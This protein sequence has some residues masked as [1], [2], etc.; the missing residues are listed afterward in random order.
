MIAPDE[1]SP[2]PGEPGRVTHLPPHSWTSVVL[3]LAVVLLASVVCVLILVRYLGG[4]PVNLADYTATQ[5]RALEDLLASNGVP[6]SAIQRTSDELRRD[7]EARWRHAQI[8]VELPATVS[9]E[10][11]AKLMRKEMTLYNAGVR[12]EHVGTAVLGVRVSVGERE[13]AVVKLRSPSPAPP[14]RPVASGALDRV[15]GAAP[16]AS[17]E[18]P[19]FRTAARAGPLRRGE[20]D[21]RDSFAGTETA[22]ADAGDGFDAKTVKDGAPKVAI[23]VDDG[24]E[25]GEV[26]DLI[27][28]LSPDLTISILPNASSAA[29][30]AERA[31]ALGFEVMLHMPMEPN[32]G[33]PGAPG[34]ITTAMAAAEIRQLTDEALAH[35]PG[36][37]GANNHTGSKFTVDEAAMQRFLEVLKEHGHYFVDSRTT[38]ATKAYEVARRLEVRAAER[39]VFL[40][41]DPEPAS[42]RR[43]AQLLIDAA[44][45]QGFAIGICHFRPETAALLGEIIAEIE[46]SGVE[47]VHVSELVH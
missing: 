37:A 39:D 44:K 36:A 40:D 9:A 5:I 3:G 21:A 2:T 18:A 35:V 20:A 25:N 29:R 10:G 1:Q 27:L 17:T 23:I 15:P 12:E 26:T 28:S 34:G 14:A 31:R 16:S 42:I 33:G 46:A 13:F 24:G 32:G 6:R 7:G 45:A 38:D 47:L 19:E 11:M 8:E 4:R 22:F 30:V 43:Q 41:N